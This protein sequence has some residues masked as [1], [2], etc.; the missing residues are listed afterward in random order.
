MNINY[1]AFKPH[2]GYG[3]AAMGYVKILKK[4]AIHNIN[5][6]VYDF[7]NKSG[8]QYTDEFSGIP[9]INFMHIT[10][11]Y[12][13]NVF[14]QNALNFLNTVFETNKFPESWKKHM[15]SVDKIAVPC[16]WN[17]NT[18]SRDLKRPIYLLPHLSQFSGLPPKVK[19]NFL[20]I[21]DDTFVFLTVSTWELRKNLESLIEVYCS[22]F[23][24]TD[25]VMLVLKTSKTNITVLK[26]KWLLRS[27]YEST[28]ASL[29][30]ILK[31]KKN[32]PNIKI[33]TD[34]ITN[35]QMQ[36][37]YERCN[38][39]ITL[40]HGEGWGMGCYEAAWYGKPVIA[41]GYGGYLDYLTHDNSYLLPYELIPY[42]KNCWDN[43]DDLINHEYAEPSID[44]AI[45]AMR[46]V[47]TKNGESVERAKKLRELVQFKYSEKNIFHYLND[48]LF[49]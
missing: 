17:Q 21:P 18:F 29:N 9:D 13:P 28:E 41:T 3:V 30:N 8:E 4:Y 35:E 5:W 27:Y 20:N 39:Y 42:K 11:N 26:K 48:F 49:K 12:I 14:Q 19:T 33:V 22:T 32:A 37:L 34:I 40:T 36:E 44:A 47:V 23:S 38:T 15:D 45:D 7:N 25:N 2:Y 16:T 43:D 10:P 1:H 46:F 31:K 6:I 24:A